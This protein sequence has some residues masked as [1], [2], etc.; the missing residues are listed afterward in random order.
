MMTGTLFS[1]PRASATNFRRTNMKKLFFLLGL[2]LTFSTG[3][4]A[5]TAAGYAFTRTTGTYSSIAG[6]GTLIGS[7]ACDDCGAAGIPIGFT[8]NFCGVSYTTCQVNSNGVVSLSNTGAS[9]IV[10]AANISGAGW[11]MPMWADNAGIG[12][13]GSS[14][15]CYYQTT[16]AP[17]NRVF[18]VEWADWAV[19]CF[20]DYFMNFQIKLYEGTNRVEYCYGTFVSSPSG[21]IG[22]ANSTTDF[23][24]LPSTASPTTNTSF[25][26]YAC[27]LPSSG[28]ILAF[29]PPCT[30]TPPAPVLMTGG[31]GYCIG[32]A[33]VNVGLAGSAI[34]INYQ[35]YLAGSPVGSPVAGVGAGFS[36]GL[37]TA[38]G[39]YTATASNPANG[40]TTNMYGSKTVIIYSLPGTHT[41]TG[42]GN[43]CS[44]GPG[45]VIGLGSSDIGVKYQLY[46]GGVPVVSTIVSGTGGAISFPAQTIAGTYTVMATM[47]SFTGC[48]QLMTGSATV[49]VNSLPPVFS[50]TGGGSFCFG[51]AGMAVGLAG[52]TSGVNYQ[53]Y[54]GTTAVGSPVAGTG[55]SITFGLQTVV[56]TYTVRAT[57]A[58]TGCTSNMFG[59]VAV[60]TLPAPVAYLMTGGGGYCTGSVGAIVGLSGSN[61]GVNY[62]LFLAGSPVGSPVTGTGSALSFG[63]QTGVGV[64][65]V[66]GTNASSGCTN[67][68]TGSV[69]V[70]INPLPN[71]YTV[72]G[73]GTY[74]SGGAGV[75][76]GLSSS[77]S[78]VLYQLYRGTTTIGGPVGGTGSAI[79][80]GLHIIAGTYTVLAYNPSTGCSRTMTGS[81]VITVTPLPTAITMSGG[82][83]YCAGGTG[84]AIGL[85]ASAIGINYQLYLGATP[86]GSPVAGT[87]GAL[88]FGLQTTAGTY[89]ATGTNPS[90][91]CV[92]NMIGS[93]TVIIYALPTAYTVTG[94]GAYCAGGTGVAVGLSGSN[95]GVYYQ[96]YRGGLPV[97]GA[98][99]G[100]TGGTLNFGMQ[101]VAGV[102][103]IVATTSGASA[104]TNTMTGSVT[105]VVN[106]LPTV[107]TV[108]GGGGYCA[109]GSGSVIGLAS[110]DAGVNYQLYRGTATVGSPV[111]GTGSA[112]S[113]GP[114]SVAG[115]YTIKATNAT[116]GCINTMGS[117]AVTI[118]PLPYAFTVSGGGSYCPGGTGKIVGLTGSTVGTNYQL[119]L[120]GSPVGSPVAGTGTTL[121]FGMHTATGTYTVV[122]TNATTGCVNN[123]AGS[124]T[125]S[126]SALP[127]AYTV[128]GGGG[129]CAGS[130]GV[131]VY[132]SGSSTGVQYQLYRGGSAVGAP[133]SGT[134][135]A[136]SFGIQ[137]VA[138][139]YTVVATSVGTLCNNSMTGS[140]TVVVNPL[141]TVRTVL[142][143]G[144]YCAGGSGV[145]VYVDTGDAGINYQLYRGTTAVGSPVAGT[146]GPL[147]FGSQTVAGTY[148]VKATDATTGCWRSMTGSATV[149]VIALPTAY[150]VTGGGSY[151]AGGVGLPVYLTGSQFGVNYQ[152]YLS[153]SPVGSPVAG[154][155]A[156]IN[157]GLQTAAGVYT[158]VATT[159]SG[160][161]TNSMTG[162]A[163]IVVNSAPTAY[164][165]TGGGSLCSGGT[166]VAVGLASS[167][168]GVNYQLYRGTTSVG[169]P[170]AGT[171]SAISFG[172]QSVAGTYTVKATLVTG[173]CISTMTG[174]VTITVGTV[175]VAV[176]MTGGGAYCSGGTG[177]LIGLSAS[178]SGVNYQLYL[179]GSPVGSP[180]AGAGSSISFGL[181]TAAGVYTVIATNATTGCTN[182]MTGSKT[183]SISANP[184]VYTVSGGGGYCSGGTGSPIYLSGSASGIT[185][186]LFR[187][188]TPV[189]AMSGTGSALSWGLYT[190]AGTYTI[191]ATAS[192]T[193][194]TS[195]MSGSAVVTVNPLPTVTGT[196][197]TMMPGGS[198]TLTGSISGGSWSSS[199]ATIATVG[200]TTG[201]VT[202]ASLGTAVMTYTLPTGCYG[203]RIVYVTPT[204][205]KE[206]PATI[207]ESTAQNTFSVAPN[208]S[209]GVFYVK[210]TLADAVDAEVAIQ[211]TDMAGRTISTI[212]AI[213]KN[214]T[215]DEMISLGNVAS[216]MYLVNVSSD[217]G[218]QVFHMVVEQ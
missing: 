138:G 161:C 82:G 200:S 15:A 69:T 153:G 154:T 43:Y 198:I 108:T 207:E 84:V 202:G 86:V 155:T 193:G 146:G 214:G 178:V 62:Q 107:Y 71:D 123:M 188:G 182:T 9:F 96:L 32:G 56:G 158:V 27:T 189:Y 171:G 194:C 79:T 124:V 131:P 120:A 55:S 38:A 114:Q 141:P 157:F 81:A 211:V 132:L 45:V 160:G 156:A 70:S 139:V 85:T 93:K 148:T 206:A 35:L 80:F 203:T 130:T 5:Q 60:N 8:F 210:G 53:L 52:S 110:S 30:G 125:I 91:G 215:L 208:P 58:T 37:Q 209:R 126:I 162:S 127:T 109:G 6:T 72:T 191:V 95:S 74:C 21:T 170:V 47:A 201:V 1:P 41:V 190:T 46:R 13:G 104:C 145:G 25:N 76:I 73:G 98:I 34:G 39:V 151:C 169:S 115:T 24:T 173:G 19:C 136:L 4:Y 59:S 89:T 103:T 212:R 177:V 90:N 152:L 40:C 187:S 22:I 204:G 10:D 183:V 217:K 92:N 94:G 166:G 116:T 64:Y 26:D 213:A 31:G 140:V 88:S 36:F 100:G 163:T 144:S 185:Y 28:E 2:I 20:S 50:V 113:F 142:G 78:G 3:S 14:P 180:V 16:G 134:G 196:I 33:G 66:V 75:A 159:A 12:G 147:S 216:G 51:G 63:P 29:A 128:L 68:M 133:L 106:P 174:S 195:S 137:T 167:D 172:L 179:G 175:P 87:G 11:L 135:G 118:I 199:N 168:A 129:Y 101:T 181:Q 77:E 97:A 49:T 44:G 102:Y 186:K 149:T 105:V 121:S 18:T 7:L 192:G 111:A 65:T 17:G 99:L 164:T 165:V 83:G 184:T 67:N 150:T 54:R 57:D 48:M 143:G 197:Y 42:G 122:A 218:R 117:V 112:I 119:F 176:S 205:R 23:Q 61:G